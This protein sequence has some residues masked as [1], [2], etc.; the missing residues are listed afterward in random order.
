L[1]LLLERCQLPQSPFFRFPGLS[2]TPELT[3]YLAERNIGI[4]STDLDSFDFRTRKPDKVIETVMTKLD[5][6]G[7]GI[8]L[9]HDFQQST[10]IALPALLQ[11]LKAKGFKIVHLKAKDSVTSL[12]QYDAA[13]V[14]ARAGQTTDGRS[15]AS[16]VRTIQEPQ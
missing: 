13:M 4:F 8:V 11:Q 1:N 10:A 7:K 12:P 3:A 5:K 15:T 16:V 9:L 14:K 2:Q 6:R